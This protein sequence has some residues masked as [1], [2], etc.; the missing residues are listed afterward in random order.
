ML[1]TGMPIP[2]PERSGP[3]VAI[4]VNDTP[5]LVDFGPGVVRRAAAAS[6]KF[7]GAIA[8]LDVTQLR[9]A[10]LTHLHSDHSAGFP[11]LI[12]TPWTMGRDVPL[13]VYGPEGINEMAGHLLKAYQEDIRYRLYGLEPANNQGWRVNTHW[14]KVSFIQTITLE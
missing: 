12:L 2:N 6:P 9:T 7:G 11:D 4:V 10:F 1:G 8:G 5:Y 3:A 13:E 14:K